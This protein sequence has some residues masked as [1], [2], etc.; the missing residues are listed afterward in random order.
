MSEKLIAEIRRLE[1]VREELLADYN[2][3]HELYETGEW[4]YSTWHHAIVRDHDALDEIDRKIR[5]A[6]EEAGI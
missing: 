5:M 3:T 1:S 6:K 4:D 2:A